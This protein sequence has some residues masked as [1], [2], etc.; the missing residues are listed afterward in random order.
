MIRLVWFLCCGLSVISGQQDPEFLA[1]ELEEAE[2]TDYTLIDNV[3]RRVPRHSRVLQRLETRPR[4]SEF[5][6]RA[7][8]ISRYAFTTV[9]CTLVNSGSEAREGVFEMQ[10]PATAFISNF[11]MV[12]GDRV[13]H[14]DVVGKERKP[15]NAGRKNR[16]SR[17]TEEGENGVEMFQASGVIPRKAEAIFLLHYEELLQ[18]R[19]G[20]YQYTISIRP[21]QLVGKLRVEVN[22]LENSGINSLEVP[23]LRKSK[24]NVTG[25]NEADDASPP[26]STVVGQTKTLAKVTFSPTVVQQAKIARNGILG[27]FIIRYDVNREL[28]VGDVQVLNGYFVHCFAPKDLPPLPKNV[29]FV[30]DTSA[31]M[32]GLKLRQTKEALFTILQDL[33]S[34]DHFNIIGF[35]NR[36]KIWQH[37]QLMPVTPNNIRDAKIYIHNLSPTGGTNINGALQIST[38]ILSDY[39]AQ[40]D[41]EPQSVSLII[42]LTDGRP[43]AGETEAARIINNT[44]EAIRN[45]FCLFTIGIGNDVD[46]KLLERLA[47]ENCGMMRR[48]REDEDAAAQ[49]KGFYDEIGTPLLSDIR[50]DYPTS[51]VDQVTQN[52]FPNYF[53]GSEIVIAGKLFNK[54]ANSLHVEVTA[55]NNDKYVLLKT[56]VAINLSGKNH[57][58]GAS[59]VGGSTNGQNYV[60]R[61]WSY[62]T[63][64]ELLTSWLK[65]DNSEEKESLREKAKE[66][67]L[68]YHFVTPFTM[69]KMKELALQAELPKEIYVGPLMEDVGEIVQGLQGHRAPPVLDSV[70]GRPEKQ[71]TKVTKTS[72]DGDPHFVVDFPLSKLTVC[73]NIDG[74]PGDILRLV[75]DHKNSGVTVNG[76]L[77]GAPAPRHGH[78]KQRTYFRS[79][80]I[81]SNKPERS[82]LEVTPTK[83][84]LDDGKRLILPCDRTAML[85]SKNLEVSIFA[86]SNVTV[87]LR[88]TIGFVILIHH[89]KNPAPYQKDHLGFYISNSKGLSAHSHGLLGQF[90]HQ[91]VKLIQEPLRQSHPMGSWNQTKGIDVNSGNVLLKLK[92]RLVPVVWKQRKIYNGE[93]EVDCWFAKNNAEKLIDG[94]YRDYLASHPFDTGTSNLMDSRL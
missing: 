85:A 19:L 58:G 5:S 25:E 53:N 12:I 94:P 82:Y 14:G 81:L 45:K 64:K 54:T 43:T 31:S 88:G 50:V 38:K 55:S 33:R 49:L 23:P 13:Y 10:I 42:F 57:I 71:R 59:N 3:A 61:A 28:S 68:M 22:I 6:V 69:L 67:A 29:V 11:T 73:F 37:D 39:I 41:I 24:S 1:K 4:M 77:I 62:L 74:E 63:I 93:Q 15:L 60:E 92:G 17:P 40:N 48:V 90:L 9:S 26:P 21:Q 87:V 20:K 36:I 79:I 86:R 27:D 70:P 2:I 51:S 78:K 89:Y 80:T 52:L 76:Q 75:S 46:Y 83:V 65:S 47:L 84:I 35:S 44:K 7:T 16:Y 91:D 66:L 34:E 32:V 18:R 72:A 56:D 8:I 30:L